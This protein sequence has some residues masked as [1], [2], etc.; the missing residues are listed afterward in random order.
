MKLLYI[1]YAKLPT[2]K[3]HGVQ[4][5]KMCEEFFKHG[6]DVELL[7]AKNYNKSRQDLF[8]YY[9]IK[10]K[11]K[12]SEIIFFNLNNW[13]KIGEI[14]KMISFI[15]F[16]LPYIFF[17]K[18]DIVYIRGKYY[19]YLT[20]FIKNNIFLE[21]HSVKGPDFIMKRILKKSRGI[22]SITEGIKNTC[23]DKYNVS[24]KKFFV[25]PDAVDLKVFD[26]DLTKEQARKKLNLP[27]NK[28]IISYVGRFNTIGMDKGINDILES[29]KILK[30]EKIIF[31]AVGGSERD[32]HYYNEKA[33][34]LNI[35]KQVMLLGYKKQTELAIYQKASDILLMPFPSIEHYAFYM[36]PMKMFEYMASKRPIIASDLPS[37]REVLNENNAFLIEPD[38][39]DKLAQEIKKVLEN[40]EFANQ[41]AQQAFRDAQNYTWDKRVTNI[42]SFINRN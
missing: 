22:I 28:K 30:E 3:A 34:N 41:I 23:V 19:C 33:A 20:S 24:Q 16:A 37:I 11:F 40:Q 27:L 36:S 8:D 9:N 31:I 14:I 2:Q 35:N 5:I 7:I 10:N 21:L 26:L 42:I 4:I 29:L 17:R 38:N 13:G 18:V 6:I 15:F 39:P 32:I 12:V 1:V 25:A